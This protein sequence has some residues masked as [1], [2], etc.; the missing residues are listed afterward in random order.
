M[1]AGERVV[2]GVNRFTSEAE[3]G[4]ELLRIDEDVARRQAEKLARVRRERD[5]A[6][7]VGALSAVV[8]A[9]Q[10]TANLMSPILDAVRSYAS[11]GEICGALRGVFG[12]YEESFHS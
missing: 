7:V 2:V 4:L 3:A 11:V 8:E 5:G 1:E 10:G 12:E 9:A 6:K